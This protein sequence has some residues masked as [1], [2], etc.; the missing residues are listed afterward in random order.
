MDA[1]VVNLQTEWET[2]PGP[3]CLGREG[4]DDND[5]PKVNSNDNVNDND[6][7]KPD[8]INNNY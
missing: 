3:P 6:N 1:L 2:H 5:N 8:I 4:G 7:L